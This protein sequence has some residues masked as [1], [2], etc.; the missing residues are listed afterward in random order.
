VTGNA[1]TGEPG[2][3][4]YSD[5][6]LGLRVLIPQFNAEVLRCDWGIPLRDHLQNG[7]VDYAAGLPGRVYCGF[8]QAY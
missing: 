4:V 1:T 3:G 7:A 2:L 5:V 6:G 8:R